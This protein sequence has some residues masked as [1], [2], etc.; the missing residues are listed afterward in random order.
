MVEF[1]L[2][3]GEAAIVTWHGHYARRLRLQVD[4]LRAHPSQALRLERLIQELPGVEHVAADPRSGR[5]LVEYAPGASLLDRIRSEVAADGVQQ[6]S[7]WRLP[8]GILQGWLYPAPA[9]QGSNG[10]ED[11]HWHALTIEQVAAELETSVLG[12]T[13]KEAELRQGRY[14]SNL[15]DELAPRSN[16]S[17]LASQVDNLPSVLLLGSSF[18]SLLLGDHLDAASIL[19]VVGLNTTAGY[20]VE[21][22]NEQLLDSWRHLEAGETQVLRDGTLQLAAASRLVPGDVILCRSG[23]IIPADARVIDAH[24]LAC[25]EAP[26]TGES[27]AQSKQVE[28]VPI[29]APFAERLS[30]LFAGSTV[31]H[32][33]GRAIVVATGKGTEMAKV[34]A[35]LDRE[36]APQAPLERR[37]GD[38]GNRIAW[39]AVCSGIAAGLIGTLRGRGL[40]AGARDAVAL[41]VAA[42]PE[43]LPVVATSALVRAMGRL[44]ER[45]MVV[46]RLASAETLGAVTVICADK[47]GTL[48]YNDMQLEVV[49]VDGKA[50]VPSELHADPERLFEDRVSLALAAAVLNSDVDVLDQTDGAV[51]GSSTERA[52]VAAAAAAGL[53]RAALRRDYP[54]RLLHER[55]DGVHYVVSIHGS[56]NGGEIAFMKGAPEQVLSLCDSEGKRR[57]HESRKRK[58]LARNAALAADGLRVLALAWRRLPR[59]PQ[60]RAESGYNL[61]GLVGLRDPLR[62]GAADTIDAAARAGVRTVIATGDQLRTAQSVARSIGLSGQVI[63]G[64]AVSRMIEN[65]EFECLRNA[66]AFARVTPADKVAIVEALRQAGEIV[67][68]VGDGINDAP[69]LKAADIG[70]AV[71]IGSSDLA[72]QAADL[73]MEREDLR[74][75]LAAISE[76]RI[77]QDNLRRALRYLLATNTAEVFLVLGTAL[78]GRTVL[79]PLQLLWLNL[80]SDTLPA[81]AL[82][83]QPGNPDI[84]SRPPARPEAPLLPAEAKWNIVRDG[85]A[86]AGFGVAALW[87]GGAP[88]AFAALAGIELAYGAAC[89]APGVVSNAEFRNLMGTAV[90][91]Q[92]ST[93]ALPPLRRLLGLPGFAGTAEWLGFAA[94]LLAPWVV[95]RLAGGEVIVRHNPSVV[96]GLRLQPRA[97]HSNVP[98]SLKEES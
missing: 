31:V 61:I 19:S 47:T 22:K 33:H 80:L 68:M 88:V 6:L 38:L 34:G 27:E 35:L 45:G 90:A 84:L 92:T 52:L 24:R 70:V 37:Y 54:R 79:N 94:G 55:S 26:L 57:L 78:A 77:V 85:A 74:A 15:I 56:P 95:K 18:L 75:I 8:S 2:D 43:G 30:M 25:N 93:F 11:H 23:D 12:L 63:E 39:A 59:R 72:R 17:I 7:G 49:E 82:A 46:R 96:T 64:S 89:R 51:V 44:R 66:S 29:D 97:K 81:L 98:I 10:S 65:G 53:D 42:I 40:L 71:G 4:G 3:G 91:L 16:L 32:G 5:V 73:V 21:H 1:E 87:L 36:R 14:G 50:F 83:L 69:A 48:T 60:S 28:S 13:A 9:S 86:M 41:A 67:A 62:A 20:Q 58:L 76:G